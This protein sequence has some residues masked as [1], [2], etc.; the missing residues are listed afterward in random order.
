LAASN[1]YLDVLGHMRRMIAHENDRFWSGCG[2]ADC[3]DSG[4]RARAAAS[5]APRPSATS[6]GG[7]TTAAA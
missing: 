2:S 7:T 3:S 6:D 4:L 5:A 1:E